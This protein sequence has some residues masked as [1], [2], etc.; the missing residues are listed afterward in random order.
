MAVRHA[1]LSFTLW[2]S[3]C[4]SLVKPHLHVYDGNNTY[5]MDLRFK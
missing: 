1:M 3:R 2:F 5:P 4:L